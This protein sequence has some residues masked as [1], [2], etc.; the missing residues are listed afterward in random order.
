MRCNQAK[1]RLLPRLMRSNFFWGT[2]GSTNIQ[3]RQ[4]LCNESS[5][6]FVILVCVFFFLHRK[7][8]LELHPRKSSRLEKLKRRKEEEIHYHDECKRA[9]TCDATESDDSQNNAEQARNARYV[10]R[11]FFLAAF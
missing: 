1:A 6:L 4:I 9:F 3:Y 5:S 11:D 10:F 8:F 2:L 7:R